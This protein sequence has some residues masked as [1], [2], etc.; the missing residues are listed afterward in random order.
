MSEPE[1]KQADDGKFGTFGGVF[2]PSTLTILGVILF[3]RFGQVVGQSGVLYAIAI[4]LL[5]KLITTLTA[6]SLAATATNTRIKGGGAYYLISR[7]LG[8]EFGGAIGLVFYLAQA[9][10]VSMYVIGFTEAFLAAFPALGLSTRIFASLVNVVV[11]L[12]VYVGAGWTIKVQYGILGILVLSLVSFFVGAVPQ[13]SSS[14]LQANLQ[15]AFLEGQG[16]FTMFALFFPAVTGIMAGANMSGDLRSPSKSLPAGTFLAIGFTAVVYLVIGALLAGTRGH[17]ELIA[18]NFIMREIAWSGALIVA[19]VFAA[20][21][22][23]ALGSMMGAPRI[24]Q[25]L[26]RD[27]IFPSIRSFARG[28]GKLNEPR[29]ATI[30]TFAIAQAGILLRDLDVLA[31]IITMFFMIT[32]GTLNLACFYEAITKNPS[33]RPTFRLSHWSMALAGALGCGAVMFLIEP[34]WAVIAIAAMVGLHY[35]LTRRQLRARWGDIQSGLAFQ[36]VRKALLRLEEEDYHP[37]NWR[38]AVLALSGGAWSRFHLAEYGYWLSSS[39]GILTLAQVLTG[40]LDDRHE[41]RRREE[42]QLRKFIAREELSAF[43]AV[44]VDEDLFAGIK[45][46]IQCHGIGG[47]R[48]NVVLLGWTEDPERFADFGRLLRLVRHMNRSIIAIKCDEEKARWSAPPGTLD[49]W[50]RGREH[51][52]FMLVLCYLLGKND[53]WIDREVRVF[54]AIA[55][56]A[57]R[58]AATKEMQEILATAR[59]AARPEI[60]VTDSVAREIHA[61]SADAALVFLG[62]NPPEEG[63][64]EA[65]VQEVGRFTEKLQNV[66]LVSDSGNVSLEA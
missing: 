23:S 14:T 65:F 29:S 17:T 43:P 21:L 38:P 32:Y 3:L 41:A 62:F 55:E 13:F 35:S 54:Y 8:L 24:L 57:E 47:L 4:I 25:A 36:R 9:I 34:L 16:F 6:F 20:T 11:F 49:V 28:A 50:W 10:S 22:S 51:G 64:E 66:I 18:D 52:A 7:S 56:E 15:P 39:R 46:L 5:A 12:C 58:A 33:Y 26:A 44:V 2:V 1:E 60:I 27:K 31:P 37:K 61:R 19:G 48:S 59:I 42:E 53:A 45:S 63:R 30:L 40:K